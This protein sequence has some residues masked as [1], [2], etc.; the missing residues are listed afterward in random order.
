MVVFTCACTGM[1]FCLPFYLPVHICH[2]WKGK[3]FTWMCPVPASNCAFIVVSDISHS[4]CQCLSVCLSVCLSGKKPRKLQKEDQSRF[5]LRCRPRVFC[6]TKFVIFFKIRFFLPIQSYQVRQSFLDWLM[7]E[8]PE[9]FLN[10]N[11]LL[12]HQIT[13]DKSI[14]S[15]KTKTLAFPTETRG[16]TTISRRSCRN[17]EWFSL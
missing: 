12:F 4:V 10:E 6:H 7:V 8:Y 1:S 2:T 15:R 5:R 9:K 13:P 16:D 3:L 17:R 11:F 14:A